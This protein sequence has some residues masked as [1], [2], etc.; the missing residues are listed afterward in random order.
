MVT[1][2][3]ALCLFSVGVPHVMSWRPPVDPCALLTAQEVDA[4]LGR[5][6]SKAG[7]LKGE[8]GQ[9][10][11]CRFAN[12]QS[13]DVTLML[14]PPSASARDDHALRPDILKEEKPPVEKVGGVGDGA[15][16]W[17]DSVEILVGDRILTVWMHRTPQSVPPAK[18]KAGLIVLAK[19]VVERLDH[20]R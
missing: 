17:P 16:Y 4:A 20:G 12:S 1:M 13:G 18:A 14:T 11:Q 7:Q 9:G 6:G 15:Y 5:S 8:G 2:L 19:Q 10:A 3:L